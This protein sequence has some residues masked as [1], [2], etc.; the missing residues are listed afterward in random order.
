MYTGD[1]FDTFYRP[2]LADSLVADSKAMT[3]D[4]LKESLRALAKGSRIGYDEESG[5]ISP[6][7]TVPYD[8]YG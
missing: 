2:Q 6:L 3:V 8:V 1:L 4:Q 7:V 5:A